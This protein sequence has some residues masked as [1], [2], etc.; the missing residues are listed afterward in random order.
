MSKVAHLL[1]V[2]AF[3]RCHVFLSVLFSSATLHSLVSLWGQVLALALGLALSCTN[4]FIPTLAFMGLTLTG[5]CD[6]GN[7]L[8]RF[9][10]ST[11][12]LKFQMIGDTLERFYL[13]IVR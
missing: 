6:Q 5:M 11:V 2:I 1:T 3:G 4:R 13:L 9:S 7:L 12:S 8:S 10:F